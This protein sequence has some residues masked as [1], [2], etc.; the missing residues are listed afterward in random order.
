MKLKAQEMLMHQIANVGYVIAESGEIPED[1]REE[2][3]AIC[4]KEMSRI[5]KLFG[6]EDAWFN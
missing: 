3:T 2:F 4:F 1:I 6:Y 5:A